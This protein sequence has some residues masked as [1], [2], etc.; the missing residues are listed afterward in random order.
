MTRPVKPRRRYDSTSRVEQAS[1]SRRAVL[2]AARRLFL[3]RGYA[4][5]TVAAIAGEAG[6]SVETVYKAF[7]NK[8]GLVKAV[9]DVSVVGDDDP[10]PMLQRDLVRRIQAESDPRRKLAMYGAHLSESA[11]RSVPVQ[12][13]VRA[14]AASDVGAAGVW[15]QML[16]ERLT[17]MTQFAHELHEQGH[18]RGDVSVDDARDVLWTYNAAELYELLV[19][20]RS[21]TP[22]RYGRWVADALVAALLP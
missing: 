12:L 13:L 1:R 16:T 15:E 2:E 21:W 6:V 20:R 19:M 18:L 5:T 11:P 17:G 22:D 14:A 8:P 4:A 10:V 9:F 7:G 3:D